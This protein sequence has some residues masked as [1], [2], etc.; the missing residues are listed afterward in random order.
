MFQAVMLCEIKAVQSWAACL[1]CLDSHLFLGRGR[2]G[3]T[4]GRMTARLRESFARAGSLLASPK[5][6]GAAAALCP[7]PAQAE[8]GARTALGFGG[9]S[10][11]A[12]SIERSPCWPAC[13]AVSRH[14]A[15]QG[16]GGKWNTFACTRGASAGGAASMQEGGHAAHSISLG[17][18]WSRPNDSPV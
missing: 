1:R 9:A 10:P 6:S 11:V 17:L 2:H 14:L 12:V 13:P 7:L 15:A 8:P 5:G 18:P 16:I 4:S 3:W